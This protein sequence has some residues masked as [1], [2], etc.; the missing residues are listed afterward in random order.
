MSTMPQSV[1]GLDLGTG[2]LKCTILNAAGRVC[3]SVA[4]SYPTS[5]PH[6]GWAEQNPADW[7]EATREA[8]AE[9]RDLQPALFAGLT[10]IGICSAAHIPVLLDDRRRV[11]RPAI[12][13]SDQRS[14]DEV[15]FL[16]AQCDDVLAGQTLNQAGCT[17]TLPQLM[18][19]RKHEPEAFDRARTLLS[20]KD[21]LIFQLTGR[22]ATDH[23][24][25][26]ATLMFDVGRKVWSPELARVAGLP[27]QALPPAFPPLTVVGEVSDTAA[28]AFGLP[29]GVPVIAGTLDSAAELVGCG[30][31]TPREAGMIMVGTSGGIMAVTAEPSRHDG[32]ITYPHVVDGL[33]YKQ[34]GTNSC[35]T[36]LQW[37]RNLFCSVQRREAADFSYQDLDELAATAAPG[38]QGLVFH[39]YLQGERAPYWNPDLR[40]SFSGI[41]QNHSGPHFVRAVMEGVAFSL[42]DCL[43]MF[44]GHGLTMKKAVMAGGVARSPVWSQ[45]ITD[46]LELETYTTGEGESAFGAGLLAA[47]ARGLFA[48]IEEAVQTGVSRGR[49][50]T[51]NPAVKAVYAD[52][53]RR[54][55]DLAGYYNAPRPAAA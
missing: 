46:V 18:W 52:Q 16:K 38:A 34:A 11:V 5:R 53:F 15:R 54:Y 41:D 4:R 28:L 6:S 21:Y 24:S 7:C 36:S 1:L 49:T 17:W 30:V 9:L 37:V 12:L 44:E 42:K 55:Q 35:A 13:W 19:V 45:I 26:A 47:T 31:L 25:A 32:V 23:A 43:K 14:E 51:P 48:S 39:P 50:W 40:G 3:A 29:A 2:S 10:C 22:L 33:Y 20:S 27:L 8:L